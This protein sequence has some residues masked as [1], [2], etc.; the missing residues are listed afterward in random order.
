MQGGSAHGARACLPGLVIMAT[1]TKLITYEEMLTMP[2]AHDL[3]EEVIDGEIH[4][5]PPNKAPHVFSVENL[6][7]LLRGALDRKK[8][9]VITTNFGLVIR[10]DPVTCRVPDLAVFVIKDIVIRD[11]YFF[12][13]P[14]LAVEVLSP[15]NTR[16]D[17]QRL[18]RDYESIGVPEVWLLSNE[19]KTITVL[20]FVDGKLVTIGTHKSGQIAPK[21]FSEGMISI[22]AIW[23]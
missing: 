13:P 11:G 18:L 8:I 14:A 4:R 5:M 15:R 10:K 20:Q 23:P 16:R 21:L 12:S 1:T 3:I 6:A 9:I 22:Q 17:Q 7:D 19:A 2:E